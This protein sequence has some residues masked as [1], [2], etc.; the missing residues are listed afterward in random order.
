MSYPTVPRVANI[1]DEPRRLFFSNPDHPSPDDRDVNGNGRPT[2]TKDH[3]NAALFIMERRYYNAEPTTLQA[4][5]GNDYVIG[6][7]W[8]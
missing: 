4:A 3:E 1:M 2:G 5:C 7:Y 8:T 6:M